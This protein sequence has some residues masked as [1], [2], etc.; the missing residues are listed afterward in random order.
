VL[1]GFGAG[2]AEAMA[3][4][5]DVDGLVFTGSTAVGKHLMQ[6]AGRSNCGVMISIPTLQAFQRRWAIQM[7]GLHA[8][9]DEPAGSV[10]DGGAF[11]N[12]D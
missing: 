3:L 12:R 1:P 2:C 4:H 9:V 6:C 11:G 5:M 10:E 8:L 7:E